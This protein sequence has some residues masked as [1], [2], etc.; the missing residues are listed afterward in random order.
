MSQIV[1]QRQTG[2]QTSGSSARTCSGVLAESFKGS[3][4]KRQIVV[5]GLAKYDRL[6]GGQRGQTLKLIN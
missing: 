3:A 5:V 6:L 2:F 4:L 1:A